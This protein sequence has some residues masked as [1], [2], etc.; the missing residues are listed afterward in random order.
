MLHDTITTTGTPTIIAT[1]IKVIL[2]PVITFL[3]RVDHAVAAEGG[4]A[5]V[6]G[7]TI[8]VIQVTLVTVFTGINNAVTTAGR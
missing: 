8:V 3:T 4:N 1:T 7:T 5:T 6:I 2:I